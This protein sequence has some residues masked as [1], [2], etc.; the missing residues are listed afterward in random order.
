M[1]VDSRARAGHPLLRLSGG[2][3]RHDGR[4]GCRSGFADWPRAR[5]PISDGS[6][7]SRPLFGG[8]G[9]VRSARTKIRVAAVRDDALS[10]EGD[11]G[12]HVP[13]RVGQHHL[14]RDV[15]RR[16]REARDPRELASG[17]RATFSRDGG[18]RGAASGAVGS[19][20]TVGSRLR[21][22]QT[23]SCAANLA[24]KR[25][26]EVRAREGERI[27]ERTTSRSFEHSSKPGRDSMRASSPAISP[28][29][30]SITTSRAARSRAVKTWRR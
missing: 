21:G 8:D 29:T 1:P 11:P 26:E 23:S 25:G 20:I 16:P 13:R 9:L 28:T 6:D 12:R 5:L 18:D 27:S 4:A 22:S 10:R 14:P 24:R 19:K 15:S 3:C 17:R 7:L 2:L 30:A